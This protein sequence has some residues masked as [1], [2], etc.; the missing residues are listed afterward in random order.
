MRLCSASLNLC[1]KWAASYNALLHRRSQC[2]KVAGLWATDLILRH[3]N[4]DHSAHPSRRICGVDELSNKWPIYYIGRCSLLSWRTGEPSPQRFAVWPLGYGLY[5]KAASFT[6]IAHIPLGGY[7][8]PIDCNTTRL[9]YY[10]GRCLLLGSLHPR[11]FALTS[12][13]HPNSRP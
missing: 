7:A 12:A 11:P 2:D 4:Y 6:T 8:G 1:G 10:I 5:T 3:P 9:L 13:R